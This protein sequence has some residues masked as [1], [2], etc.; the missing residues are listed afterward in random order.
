MKPSDEQRMSKSAFSGG[1]AESPLGLAIAQAIRTH[2]DEIFRAAD[3]GE[4]P[5]IVLIPAFDPIIDEA[6]YWRM[7]D[8]MIGEWLGSGYERAGRKPVPMKGQSSGRCFSP[9]RSPHTVL[10]NDPQTAEQ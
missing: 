5:I 3:A 2:S 7:A 8:L 10:G 1:Y 4:P 9:V 6:I